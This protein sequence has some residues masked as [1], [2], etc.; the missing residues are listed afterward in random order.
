M[1]LGP[2]EAAVRE[3]ALERRLHLHRPELGDGE[4]EVVDGGD[5]LV[6]VV[7]EEEPG[8]L[9]AGEGDLGP[10]AHLLA[11]FEGLGVV[12]A[13]FVG[14]PRRLAAPPQRRPTLT[15]RFRY[16]QPAKGPSLGKSEAA[17]A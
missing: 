5:V 7:R 15:P 4:V 6:R 12:G 8:Q 17:V 16:R 1:A 3:G 13:R 14:L 11:D 2:Q 10:E 9:E